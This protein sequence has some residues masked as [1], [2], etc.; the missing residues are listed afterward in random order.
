[1]LNGFTYLSMSK[2]PQNINFF[3][4][5]TKKNITIK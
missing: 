1:M 5:S 3:K 4:N 2:S